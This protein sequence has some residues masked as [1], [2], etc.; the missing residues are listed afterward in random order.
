MKRLVWMI[1]SGLLV[2]GVVASV[3]AASVQG[4]TRRDGTSVQPYQRTPPD[5]LKSNNYS[6]PGN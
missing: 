6:Y 5:S 3:E 2:C 1:V 4:Y